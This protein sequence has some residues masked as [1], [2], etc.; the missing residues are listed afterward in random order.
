MAKNV[1]KLNLK[2]LLHEKDKAKNMFRSRGY[3]R[4]KRTF[5]DDKGQQQEEYFEI[6]IQ[7]VGDSKL[8]KEY[9]EKYP[10]PKPPVKRDLV[11]LDTGESIADKNI[12]PE[13]IKAH[14]EK[15]GFA[16]IYDFADEKYQK[17]FEE[18]NY[19]LMVLQI[20]VAFDVVDEF[21]IDKIDEFES[22]LEDLGFTSNQLNKIGNDINNLDFLPSGK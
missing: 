2:Q 12:A 19:K 4:I 1:K 22:W 5:I 15:Y 11:D 21:G 18:W 8:L 17:A 7:P 9:L 20:M 16:N 14:P 3:S 6:E 10:K 13:V